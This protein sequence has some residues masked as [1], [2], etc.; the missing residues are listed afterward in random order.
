MS[1]RTWIKVYCDKWLEGSISDESINVRGAWISLLALAGNGKYGDK[2]EIKA[3]HGVGFT[4]QQLTLMLKINPKMWGIARKRF[5][6]T[7]RI[8]ISEGNI[9][10][11]INWKKYQSEY[12]RTSKYRIN[13]CINATTKDTALEDRGERIEDRKETIQRKTTAASPSFTTYKEKLR[14]I[15]SSLD[16]DEEWERCQIWY[17]DH[18]RAI[19]SPSLA[20]GNWCKKEMEMRKDG[21]GHK[22]NFPSYKPLS[23]AV[24]LEEKMHE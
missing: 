4:D 9:I 12:E 7:D 11:I 17:K 8:T 3:L 21:N 18:K 23:E 6:E 20:L 1:S 2:G 16:I 19:K 24:A 5:L 15:Y 10:T 22:T 14:I 13:K